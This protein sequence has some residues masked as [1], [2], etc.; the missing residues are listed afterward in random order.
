MRAV[1]VLL[2]LLATP[3]VMGVA[4]TGSGLPGASSCV[5][6]KSDQHRSAQG[7]AN[8]HKGLCVPQDPP[9]QPPPPP[10]SGCVASAPA[11]AGTSSIDGQ[12]FVDASP[13]P[14]QANWCVQ[15]TGPVNATAV[16]DA[17]GNYIFTGLPAGTYTVCETV[18]TGWIQDFP[19]SG[20]SCPT[21]LGYSFTF[22][23][24]GSASFVYFGNVTAP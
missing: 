2:A 22:T 7:T 4:Q 15:L 23:A 16:T 18:Q 13:W 12:V 20:P 3:F 14:G 11:N 9:P 19:S 1:T 24:G 5:N 8:A 6:G 10:T 17:S 21:G